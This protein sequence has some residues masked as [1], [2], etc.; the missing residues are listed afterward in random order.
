[1][2]VCFIS[3]SEVRK[4]Q[5]KEEAE[6]YIFGF[7][8]IGEV[9]YEKEL[10]GESDEFERVA[11]L[12]KK[13]K[14]IVVSGCATNSRGIKRKSAVV[15][16][17]GK[18]LGVSDMLHV[19]EKGW[20]GGA[21]LRVYET[22]QGKM[23]VIVAEDLYFPETLKSLTDC[24]CRFLVCAFGACSGSLPSVLLR[25][26]AFLYG[27]PIYFCGEGYC[28]LATPDGALAFASPSSPVCVAYT[29]EREYHL[30]ETRRG[31]F[32]PRK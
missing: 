29:L 9:T 2:R 26:Y 17:K 11:L 22:E 10:K 18:I 24:G 21:E 7:N 15:A 19:T 6:L 28:M 13:Q 5:G 14:N 20:S 4:Y 30:V 32:L 16:E 31:I 27:V 12:S 3:G 25:A 1:M 23:G 8:G